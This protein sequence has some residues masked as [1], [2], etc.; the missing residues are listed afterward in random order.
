MTRAAT[1]RY[2]CHARQTVAW[3]AGTLTALVLL[4]VLATTLG[5][6]PR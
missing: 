4:L 1:R 5:G 3:I 6:S 2:D